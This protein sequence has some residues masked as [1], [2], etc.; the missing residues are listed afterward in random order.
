M[1]LVE[2][3]REELSRAGLFDKDSDYEGMLGTA[4]MGLIELFAQ[5]GHSGFSA[6]MVSSIF[7]K[8]S[9]YQPIT[10]L[11]GADEEWVDISDLGDGSGSQKY[12]NKRCSSV[13]KDA[14]GRTYDIHAVVFIDKDDCTYTSNDSSRDITFPYYPDVEYVHVDE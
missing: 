1:G 8:L 11:T 13:F 4:V 7:D 12:Q 6:G 2:F 5:Q 14:D 9:R 10:P 3:A